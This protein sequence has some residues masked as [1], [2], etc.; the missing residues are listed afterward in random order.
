M[1]LLPH[2][3]RLASLLWLLPLFA[4]PLLA[5]APTPPTTATSNHFEQQ[6]RPILVSK[7]LKCHGPEKQKSNLRLDSRAALLQGGKKGP[8]LVPGKPTQSRLIAALKHQKLKM[9]PSGQLPAK[10]IRHFEAWIASGAPWPEETASLRDTS[11]GITDTDRQWWAFKPLTRP[12]LPSTEGA[13]SWAKNKLDQFVFSQLNRHNLTPAPTA[14][15]ATLL[16]RLYY[17][18]IGLPPTA[19]EI[20]AFINDKSDA[21]WEKTIDRLLEDPRYG[22]HWARFWLDLVRYSDSDGWNQDALRPDIWKYR[23]YV[24]HSFNEDKPYAQFV[25]EQLAGD[26]TPGDHPQHRAAAGFLR[27]GI[28][29]YNQRDARGHWNDIM[30]ET[31]DVAGDVFFGLS[32]ACARCHDHKFD[33]ILQ[34]DYFA[35]RAFFEPIV[36][37]DDLLEA[38]AAEQAEHE[39]KMTP[40]NDKTAELRQQLDTFLEPHHAKKWKSTAG[41][42]PKEIR[43]AFYSTL[44]ADYAFDS[45]L[46]ATPYDPRAVI[47]VTPSILILD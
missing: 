26:E 35:L 14:A 23:D 30:N 40:W 6:I 28:Y 47:D 5:D 41:K 32:M 1:T 43:D 12:D 19:A 42:F 31:T 46:L 36:W 9:P 4:A 37:R 27:L 39:Q 45:P 44:S 34:R 25:R 15:K 11:D 18:L 29:E 22:E 7:C 2:T 24:I 21:A 33:P 38:T 8:A 3:W 13:Q 10:T 16:R 20:T 17:D